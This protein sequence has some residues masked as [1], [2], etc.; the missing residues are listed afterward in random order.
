M[1]P[2]WAGVL[3]TFCLGRKTTVQFGAEFADQYLK[4]QITM[5]KALMIGVFVLAYLP[6][7][8]QEWSARNALSVEGGKNYHV[9]YSIHYS[10]ILYQ[11]PA[12]KV[13]AGVGVSLMP[14]NGNLWLPFI[15]MEVTALLGKKRLL[16][17]S[18]LTLTPGMY[19][20]WMWTFPEG[21]NVTTQGLEK[22]VTHKEVGVSSGIRIGFRIQ[23]PQGGFFCRTGFT[24]TLYASSR[25]FYGHEFGRFGLYPTVDETVRNSNFGFALGASIGLGISY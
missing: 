22:T 24:P 25:P 6:S 10:R 2:R 23:K 4:K 16:F 18:G 9:N 19:Y 17:E 13:N 1:R 20:H 11:K 12:F 15:P 14:V 7:L 5:K 3:D 8:A 21:Y